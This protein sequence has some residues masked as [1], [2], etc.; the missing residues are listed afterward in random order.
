MLQEIKKVRNSR[1]TKPL[2]HIILDG[3]MGT[4]GT[5]SLKKILEENVSKIFHIRSKETTIY[6]Q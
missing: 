3:A 4:N 1:F 5:I 6:Y 2:K